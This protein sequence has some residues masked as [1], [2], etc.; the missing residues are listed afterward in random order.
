MKKLLFLIVFLITSFV[1]F[2]QVLA[3]NSGNVCVGNFTFGLSATGAGTGATYEWKDYNNFTIS[4]DQNPIGVMVPT[5]AGS[6]VYSVVANVNGTPTNVATTTLIVHPNPIA[7]FISFPTTICNNEMT[8][9]FFNGTPGALVIFSDGTNNYSV[10]LP[11]SGGTGIFTTVLSSNTTFTLVEIISATTP[12]CTAAL[13]ESVLISVGSPTATIVG[14]TNSAICSGTSTG[15]EVQGTPNAT[16]TYTIG[17]VAQPDVTLSPAGTFTIDTGIQTVTATS[18]ITY[19]L[20]NVESNPAAP[21]LSCSDS[22][23]GQTAV[24]TVNLITAPTGNTI[25]DF[26]NGQ[27]LADFSVTVMSGATIIWYNSITG[28]TVLPSNTT[29]LVEGTTYYASQNV[30]GCESNARLAVTAG[31]NLET[32]Q[33]FIKNLTYSPNPVHDEL[34]IT[35][36]DPIER[37]SIYDMLGKLIQIKE[38]NASTVKIDMV[39]MASGIYILQVTVNGITNNLKVIKN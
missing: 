28:A 38:T 35:Y 21:A 12:A 29:I 20:T 18:T 16:V 14:F 24:L 39:G 26:T 13:S 3:T 11:A 23:T 7:T 9:L 36:S 1:S 15:L 8:T 4:T 17:D 37:V 10:T 5:I 2:C 34:K 27:T 33:F 25:Q 32:H 31:T 22:I 6:Y 30:D 19:A